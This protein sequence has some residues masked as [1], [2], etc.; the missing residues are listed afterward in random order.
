MDSIE[1]KLAEMSK[2]LKARSRAK[3]VLETGAYAL[4]LFVLFVGNLI[5]LFV[6]TFNHR[7]RTIPNMLVASL[8]ISDF[9]LGA[10]SACPI[11][12]TT[13][14]T[15]EWP[16]NDTTCQYQG[17]VA[18]T[19]AVASTQT[20]ALMAVNRYF[21]IV[22]P[23]KYRRYFT[24][25]RTTI[26]ILVLW[27]YCMWAPLPYILSGYKMVFHPSKFFCYLQIDSGPFTAFLVTVYVGLPTCV[28]FFC[29]LRI[30]QTV[31]SHNTN[32]QTT[33]VANNT[34]NVEEIKIARTL[35]VI[36]VFF[37]L[38]WTPVLLIDIVDTIRGTW[39]LPREAYMAYS[40]LAT[41]SSALNPVIYGILNKNFQKEYLKVL[42]CGYC[43]SQTV[44][45]PFIRTEKGASS[46][47]TA[48]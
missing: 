6:I 7:M 22:S 47:A 40:F 33:D 5:T 44:V 3:V 19:L 24:K 35:F 25:K 9:L 2:E 4:I 10:L 15:S 27:F 23:A 13:L 34:V 31:R 48:V 26:M 39:M 36:V 11:A 8:A 37:N 20:L 28:I 38:C 18:V 29:Y 21:R 41:I 45:E 32:F 14:A 43:R 42:R 46:V 12:L 17:Y 1:E 30:F 16:F